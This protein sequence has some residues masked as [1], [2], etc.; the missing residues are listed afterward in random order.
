MWENNNISFWHKAEF[1]RSDT[2]HESGGA[3]NLQQ[4]VR[5][6]CNEVVNLM[7]L[8][9]R[10]GCRMKERH[11]LPQGSDRPRQE[12]GKKSDQRLGRKA[13]NGCRPMHQ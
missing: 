9:S 1:R 13:P 5:S 3:I 4:V 7:G 12:Q 2:F 10:Q 6:G 11:V 8:S